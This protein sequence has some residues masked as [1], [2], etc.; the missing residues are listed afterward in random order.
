MFRSFTTEFLEELAI[1]L[2]LVSTQFVYAVYA[3][4]TSHLMSIGLTP[5]FLTIYGS[6]AISFYLFPLSICFE[7]KLWPREF[8]LKLM[9]QVILLSFGGVTLF[10]VLL[11]NGVKKTSP[12][13]ATAMPNLAPGFIFIIAWVLRFER[14]N[15]KCMYGVVKI[16]GTLICTVGAITMSLLHSTTAKAIKAQSDLVDHDKVIGTIYL[17]GPS[18][19]YL[20]LLFYSMCDVFYSQAATLGDFPAPISLSAVTAFVGA[21]IT[22]V[23]QLVQ[24]HNLEISTPLVSG[25]DLVGYAL[26]GGAVSGA[27][28]SFQTWA[29]K[30]KGPVFV[31]TFNP[32]GTV[33]SVILSAITL[34]ES[35]SLGSLLGMFLM[36]SGLYCV[37]WAK[38]REYFVLEDEES[39]KVHD[40]KKPLLS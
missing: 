19:F 29:M 26:M 33:F 38:R 22:A 11:L 40:E 32:I 14:V 16:T 25:K 9:A 36:F 8:S 27:C 18:L 21:I 39:L 5:L 2:A 24:N 3:V 30:K 23:V 20:V 4:F 15:V 7:R 37:L 31:S 35:I 10:Q 6:L 28:T 1:V 12:T 17:M 13:V 34:G